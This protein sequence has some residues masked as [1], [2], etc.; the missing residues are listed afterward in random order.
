MYWTAHSEFGLDYVPLK[1]SK[2]YHDFHSLNHWLEQWELV[3]E[4]LINN[5]SNLEKCEIHKL[6]A[7]V[8]LTAILGAFGKIC[9]HKCQ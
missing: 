8:R 5:Y 7:L 6:R 9:G 2:I 1:P 3:Y 4:D